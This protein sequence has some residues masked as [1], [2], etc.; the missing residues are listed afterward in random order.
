M[1]IPVGQFPDYVLHM[2]AE[3]EYNHSKLATEYKVCSF[4]HYQ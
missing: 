1:R 4:R 2:T 3:N